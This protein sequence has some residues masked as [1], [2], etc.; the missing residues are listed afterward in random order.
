MAISVTHELSFR[1][2]TSVQ[3]VHCTL[4]THVLRLHSYTCNAYVGYTPVLHMYFYKCNTCVGYVP[5]H[6]LH[7]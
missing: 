5:T 3:H 4:A 7:V 1:C 2:I 6:I